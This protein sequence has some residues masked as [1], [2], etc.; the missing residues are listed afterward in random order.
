MWIVWFWQLYLWMWPN[1]FGPINFV[2]HPGFKRDHSVVQILEL[3][4]SWCFPHVSTFWTVL[5]WM[6]CGCP[7]EL[8][9][10]ECCGFLITLSDADHILPSFFFFVLFP[11]ILP[12]LLKSCST[13]QIFLFIP[14]F[15]SEFNYSFRSNVL[16]LYLVIRAEC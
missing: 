11:D 10:V 3:V 2:R 14:Q 12:S 7:L 1:V 16:P 6:H 4:P 15:L 8:H 9:C 13:C 5:H